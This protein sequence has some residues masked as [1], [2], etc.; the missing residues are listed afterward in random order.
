MFDLSTKVPTAKAT[1]PMEQSAARWPDAMQ[2]FQGH[3]QERTQSQQQSQERAQTEN[4]AQAA[5]GPVLRL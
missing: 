5:K 4:Q 2:Q 1:T 3:E